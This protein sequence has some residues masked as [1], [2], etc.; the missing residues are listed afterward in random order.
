MFKHLNKLSIYNEII[1]DNLCIKCFIFVKK[2]MGHKNM[3]KVFININIKDR[4]IIKDVHKL[5]H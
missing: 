5:F 2:R 1:W 4:L 3:L